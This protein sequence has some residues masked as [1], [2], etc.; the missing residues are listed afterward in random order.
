MGYILLIA[1]HW[2]GIWSAS[3]EADTWA[4]WAPWADGRTEHQL[5]LLFGLCWSEEY[6]VGPEEAVL[7]Q[8]Q[9]WSE[10]DTPIQEGKAQ[11]QREEIV[12]LLSLF[13]VE[14]LSSLEGKEIR[15]SS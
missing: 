8:Q 7:L 6:W 11:N 1:K 10:K 13:S 14:T 12:H 2:S 9:Y 5:T 4:P 15:S 3:R